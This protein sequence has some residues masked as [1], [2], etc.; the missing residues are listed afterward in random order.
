[1]RSI[2]TK[3]GVILGKF[4]FSEN[5]G[6]L[7]SLSH[8]P[9]VFTFYGPEMYAIS[10]TNCYGPEMNEIYKKNHYGP[11]INGLYKKNVI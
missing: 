9:I 2:H 7:A 11:E 3:C 10:G 4:N 5:Y 6:I 1:M 8:K